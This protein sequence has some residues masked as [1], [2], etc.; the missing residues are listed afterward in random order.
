MGGSLG[1]GR[2]GFKDNALRFEE[3]DDATSTQELVAGRHMASCSSQHSNGA[4][5]NMTYDG[6]SS[7]PLSAPPHI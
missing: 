5:S 6:E 3:Q 7:F 2:V 4:I 1:R